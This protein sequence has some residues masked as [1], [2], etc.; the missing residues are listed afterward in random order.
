SK[1]IIGFCSA[2]EEGFHQI[3]ITNLLLLRAWL[4]IRRVWRPLDIERRIQSSETSKSR[5]VRIGAALK[6][7][8]GKIQM[9][10]NDSHHERAELISINLIDAGAS[11]NQ[12]EGSINISFPSSVKQCCHSTD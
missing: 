4:R 5:Q 7:R 11:L 9:A 6:Q 3:E 2:F 1:P 10:V 8:V 12:H